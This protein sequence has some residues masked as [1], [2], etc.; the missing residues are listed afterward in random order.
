MRRILYL[1]LWLNLSFPLFSEAQSPLTY[2]PEDQEIFVRHLQEIQKMPR[3]QW[4]QEEELVAL[5]KLFLGTPYVAKTLEM[6]G[7]EKV[8]VNLRG[9]DCTTYIENVLALKALSVNPETSG[10]AQFAAELEKLRY[11]DGKLN[12]YSSRLHYFSDWVKNN[13]QKGRVKDITAALGGIQEKRAINF[14]G[15]HP[16]YYPQLSS[17]REVKQIQKIE[18]RLSEQ[19]FCYLPKEAIRGIQKD[20]RSGDILALVTS[21]K[22][23]DVTHT[24]FALWHKGDLH[25]MHASTSG[26]VVISE[27]PLVEY[28]GGIKNNIGILVVRPL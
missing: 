8:V 6:E 10:F 21:I 11:R 4:V 14:M 17:E 15:Q 3:S 12:G 27:K 19:E 1:L 18:A 24:G 23:L 9:L 26:A 28:L 2:T 16:Q 5:G 13:E 7:P 22:G 20:I 25:L